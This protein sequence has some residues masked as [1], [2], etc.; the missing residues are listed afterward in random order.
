M[1]MLHRIRQLLLYGLCLLG[2]VVICAPASSESRRVIFLAPPGISRGQILAT[3]GL[4]KPCQQCHMRDHRGNCRRII[5]YS[6]DGV[7]C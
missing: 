6:T 3:H 7:Q 1:M 5:S 4:E 2:L